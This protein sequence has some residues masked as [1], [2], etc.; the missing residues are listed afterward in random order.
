MHSWVEPRA[1]MKKLHRS[2]FVKRPL[3]SREVG[4]DGQGGAVELVGEKSVASWEVLCK[5]SYLVCKVDGFLVDL[6]FFEHEG[7]SQNPQ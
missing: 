2:A 6:E 7:H 5:F 1:M 4:C 3:P